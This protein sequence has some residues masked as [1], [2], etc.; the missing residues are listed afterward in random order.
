M[1][2]TM[3]KDYVEIIQQFMRYNLDNS[4]EFIIFNQKLTIEHRWKKLKSL[5]KNMNG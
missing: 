3:I 1:V 5:Q 2:W 4:N